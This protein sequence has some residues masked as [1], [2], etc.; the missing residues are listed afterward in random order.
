MGVLVEHDYVGCSDVREMMGTVERFALR[1]QRGHVRQPRL[2]NRSQTHL[3]SI[4]TSRM[5]AR[6]F[7]GSARLGVV[8]IPSGRGTQPD[9]A[10]ATDRTARC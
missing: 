5:A 9:N 7:C 8:S 6:P 1:G 4:G 10:A 3:T 2:R